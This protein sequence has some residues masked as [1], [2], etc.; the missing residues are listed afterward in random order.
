MTR[1]VWPHGGGEVG[2]I[3][4]GWSGTESEVGPPAGWP[5]VLTS[6]VQLIL[7]SPA[8]MTLLWGQSGILLYNDAYAVIAGARH[9]RI[10]GRSVFEAWPEISDFHRAVMAQLHRGEQL[11]YRDLPL[12]LHRNGIAEDTWLSVDYGPVFDEAGTIAGILA[13]VTETT[14]VV[15]AMQA[16]EAAE[17]ALR[18]REQELARVQKIGRIGGLEVDLRDGYHNKRSPEYLLVHGLPP[19]ASNETHEEWVQRIHPQE[20]ATVEAHFKEVVAGTGRDYQAEYRIIRPS[21]GAVRWIGAVAQIDRD[22]HGKA[23]RLVGAHID[24]TER[25][26]AEAH[27]RLLMQ[28][29][30]HRVKNSL[31]MVQAIASQT[32]RNATSLETARETFSARLSALSRAHDLLVG[33]EW[34]NAALSQIIDSVVGIQ[35]EPQRFTTQGPDVVLGPKAALALTLILHELA[36]NAVKYGA[37]SNETGRVRL[38]WRLDEIDGETQF[39][40][41]WQEEGGPEVTAPTRRGF[42]SRLIERSFPT[43]KGQTQLAFAATGLVFTLDAPLD[44]LKDGDS[45]DN[46]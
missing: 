35:G 1:E 18:M 28:E 8:P 22:E 2:A 40:L 27:Q 21:D 13:T 20:R 26:D 23:V 5:A 4:R 10:L 16:R 12:V 25:K 41:R 32:L 30:S 24:I 37:L 17:Q 29:L 7:T 46:G 11:S 39:R 33:G 3:L 34:A 38:N 43:V 45:D 19:E 6:A 44:A 31:A 42:G 36:T 14:A 9:P 15:K